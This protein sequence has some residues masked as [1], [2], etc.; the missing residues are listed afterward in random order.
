MRVAVPKETRSGEKRVAL[1]PD[2][3]SKLTKLGYEVH[4]ESGAGVDSQASDSL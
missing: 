2:V 3:V 4:V 1:V